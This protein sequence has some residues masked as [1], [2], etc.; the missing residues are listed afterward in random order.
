MNSASLAHET[1]TAPGRAALW[2]GRI[3]SGLV[4]A[5]LVMSAVAKLGGGPEVEAGFAQAGFKP[6]HLAPIGVV[7]IACVVL[8]LVPWTAF[9]G[10]ILLTGFLGGAVVTHLRLDDAVHMPIL[11]GVVVWLGL[12]LRDPRLRRLAPLRSL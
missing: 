9:L 6:E 2:T 7:E 4:A 1:N 11:V 3:L 12:F 5:L 10:A 8:Y